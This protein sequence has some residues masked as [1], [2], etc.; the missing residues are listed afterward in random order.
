MTDPVTTEI[1]RHAL[2]TISEEMRTSLRR[3]AFS[4]VVKDMLDYSCAVFDGRGRL[5]ATA[6]DIPALLAAMP[7]ALQAC[8]EKW[9][10]DVHPG[11]MF[12][13]N[14][15]YLGCGHTSDVNIFIPVFDEAGVRIGFSGAVAH[16]ADW[17]GRVAGTAA[18]GNQSIF[19]EGMVLSAVKLENA[20]VRN[21]AL[22]D[23][24]RANVR[25]PA[26][27][28]G[29]LRATIAAARTGERRMARLAERYGTHVLVTSCDALIGYS[30]RR[31]RQAI[32]ELPD[33]VYTADGYLDDN[34]VQPDTPVRIAVS[35]EIAGD[36]VTFDF[37]GT[38]A[39]MPGGMNIPAANTR[40]I[41]HYSMKCVLSDDIPF[42]E[43]SM[44]A[45][46]IVSPQGTVV[47][48]TRPAAVSDRTLASQRV[49]DVIARAFAT[50]GATRSSAGWAIGWPVFIPDS[51]SPK[52]GE[53]AVL[54]AN[55]A[56]GAGACPEHDG[57]DALDVHTANCAIIPAEIIET[58]YEFRVECYAL[59]RDSGGPGRLRGGLGIQADYRLIGDEPRTFLAEAEQS[60]PAFAPPGL[61]GGLPGAV[62]SIELERDGEILPL[63]AKGT[64]VAQPGDVVRMRAG[65]GG[66]WGDPSERDAAAVVAD[67]RAGRVSPEAALEHHG[68][69][70]PR[71]EAPQP[72]PA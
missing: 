42:N 60:N 53:G 40:G 43:G 64:Y 62:A 33:G 58:N 31:T 51:R 32:S 72:A 27:N 29:D 22:M 12:V 37:T 5:L 24:I 66:G 1:I 26:Q 30:A 38:D 70:V 16:H 44:E 17:G 3:T 54:L 56:G 19:E 47:N 18:A 65:G 7:P 36:E 34:G 41:A 63:G 49:A 15:P 50:T 55:V 71:T 57:G 4:V 39:Q 61:E 21:A 25:H 35:I 52:T 14:D 59:I 8:L 28:F 69:R 20:G 45:V 6:I 10:D 23:V 48:P 2:E 68:V 13:T 46:R 11:D 67:V 9:G